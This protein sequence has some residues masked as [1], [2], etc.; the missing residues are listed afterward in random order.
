MDLKIWNIS[1][2]FNNFELLEDTWLAFKLQ[3]YQQNQGENLMELILQLI[4]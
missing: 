3:Q 1:G 4:N 2:I